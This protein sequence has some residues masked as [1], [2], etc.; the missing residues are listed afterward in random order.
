MPCCNVEETKLKHWKSAKDQ[1]HI[2]YSSRSERDVP[3]SESR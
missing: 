3:V 2:Y 1:I